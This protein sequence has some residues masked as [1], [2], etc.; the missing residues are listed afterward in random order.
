[1]RITNKQKLLSLEFC[2]PKVFIRSMGSVA[3]L[4]LLEKTCSDIIYRPSVYIVGLRNFPL[5]TYAVIC[6]ISCRVSIW[7][8]SNALKW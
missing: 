2:T 6:P 1:M 8:F 3:T 5:L 4:A 7:K